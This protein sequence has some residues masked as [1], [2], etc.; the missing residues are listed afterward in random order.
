M[1]HQT[2]VEITNAESAMDWP[3]P[4]WDECRSYAT[5]AIL[6]AVA[7]LEA[8]INEFYLEAEDH[9]H[10]GMGS[11]PAEKCRVL[12]DAWEEIDEFSILKKYELA[13]TLC[14]KPRLVRSTEPFQSAGA[15]IE[16]R[17]ALVHYK[18]EWNHALD[19]HSK[20]EERLKGR[21]QDCALA[22]KAKGKMLW[23]PHQ[24]LG[25]GCAVWAVDSV[26]NFANDFATVIGV[27]PRFA[28]AT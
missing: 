10:V 6:L 16:L 14:G 21:F 8:S 27:P 5:A 18:P 12:A 15:L 7:A 4:H 22:L 26:R 28:L 25:A 24:C 20:L 2:C 1:F 17:N 13:V 19:R 9:A 3:Q 11:I 23:F